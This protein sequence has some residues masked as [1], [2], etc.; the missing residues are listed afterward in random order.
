MHLLNDKRIVSVKTSEYLL[1]A[2]VVI[3][4]KTDYITSNLTEFTVQDIT[5]WDNINLPNLFL[6]SSNCIFFFLF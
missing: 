6:F 3:V 5:Y 4:N 2:N 1:W